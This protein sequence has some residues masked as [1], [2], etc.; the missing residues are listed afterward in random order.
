MDPM[1]TLNRAIIAQCASASFVFR[2][3]C[4]W[5]QSTHFL[6]YASRNDSSGLV[7]LQA[8]QASFQMWTMFP[9]DTVDGGYCLQLTCR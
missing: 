7:W 5:D 2:L 3:W 1:D 9:P 6:Q 4:P 8:S